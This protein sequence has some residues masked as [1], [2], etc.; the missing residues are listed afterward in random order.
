MQD[1]VASR[2]TSGER[3]IDWF[4]HS[5]VQETEDR[6]LICPQHGTMPRKMV[7]SNQ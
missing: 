4:K 2:Y 1:I 5:L 6:D 7:I 3:I